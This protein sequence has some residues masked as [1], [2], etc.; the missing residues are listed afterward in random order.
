MTIDD[1]KSGGLLLLECVSGS[2]AYGLATS[3]SDTDIKGVF[4][5]P[6]NSFYG[7]KYIEQ[8]SNATNDEVY[9]ELERFVELLLKNNPN[10]LELLTTPQQFVLYKHPLMQQLQP[11]LF[12][13]KLCRDS[14]AGYAMTQISKARGY[15]KKIVNPVELNR[16]EVTDFC[17][18]MQGKHT[19][20]LKQW[21]RENGF[22]EQYCGLVNIRHAKG[23]YALFYDINQ[24][25]NYNGIV[26]N[27]QANDICLSSVAEDAIPIAYLFFNKEAYSVYCREYREYREWEKL[28]N[29][30]RYLMNQAHGKNYDAK[31]MMH[32][33]RLL[34]VAKEILLDNRLNVHRTNREELLAIKNGQ[35]SYE[36]LLEKADNLMQDIQV[37]FEKS[38]L[39]DMP[40]KKTA[41]SILVQ[42]REELY[43][44]TTH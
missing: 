43:H 18:I 3:R 5:L 20:P 7:L 8:V 36:S 4:Y 24:Q 21:L 31:N 15:N 39:P 17:F 10:M 33:I 34:Q 14:F 42:I 23:I 25:I 44:S 19:I 22:A 26:R 32:T 37:A 41:E 40:D 12:L 28:R 11:D 6:R 13:S 30:E 9:Y 1:I 29:E 2:K 35:F 27:K 16:K 38:T